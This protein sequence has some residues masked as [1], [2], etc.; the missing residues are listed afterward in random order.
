MAIMVL[1][2]SALSGPSAAK[3]AGRRL[4]A[5]SDSTPGAR[6]LVVVGVIDDPFADRRQPVTGDLHPARVEHPVGDD[7]PPTRQ[8]RHARAP[9]ATVQSASI[10]LRGTWIAQP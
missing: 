3:E 9:R 8:H 6:T 5:A 10:R 2:Y 1:G 7:D 4:Q